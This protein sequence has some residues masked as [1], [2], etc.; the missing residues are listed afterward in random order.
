MKVIR[1][2]SLGVLPVFRRRDGCDLAGGRA[3]AA[4]A[5]AKAQHHHDRVG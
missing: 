2:L 1:K 3:A 5:A 4:A